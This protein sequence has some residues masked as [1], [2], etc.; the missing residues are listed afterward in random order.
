M[1]RV[2]LLM[3]PKRRFGSAITSAS[4]VLRTW[5]LSS[6]GSFCGEIVVAL[7]TLGARQLRIYKRCKSI[8]ILMLV[9][10]VVLII[11]RRAWSEL[12]VG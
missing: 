3:G 7:A 5:R 6:G 12:G 4:G 2:D 10:W 9:R 1:L 11:W 8:R